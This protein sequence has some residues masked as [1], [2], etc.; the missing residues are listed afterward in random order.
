MSARRTVRR[1][2]Y[3]NVDLEIAVTSFVFGAICMLVMLKLWAAARKLIKR[4]RCTTRRGDFVTKIA[5]K[6]FYKTKSGEKVHTEV[7]CQYL[8][9]ISP[10]ELEK[11]RGMRPLCAE[12][13]VCT[14]AK[15]CDHALVRRCP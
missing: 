2:A 10:E 9:H 14:V 8:Q 4:C 15:M 1:I 11:M 5:I 7:T 13:L 12:A 6:E 3:L